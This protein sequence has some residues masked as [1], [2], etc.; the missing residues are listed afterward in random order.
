MES[1]GRHKEFLTVDWLIKILISIAA[2]FLAMTYFTVEK[3]ATDISDLKGT[4]SVIQYQYNQLSN[5]VNQ[6]ELNQKK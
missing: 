3:M 4:V 5:R 1:V 6:L 2:F